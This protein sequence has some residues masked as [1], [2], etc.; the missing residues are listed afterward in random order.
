QAPGT[1]EA[2]WRSLEKVSREAQA[3]DTFV[4]LPGSYPGIL[5]PLHSGTPEAPITFRAEERRTA[6]LVGTD[7]GYHAVRL[8][9]VSHIRLEGLH[10]RP[11][12]AEGRWFYALR[13]SHITVE[14][15][16]MDDASGG[17]PFHIE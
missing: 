2:P 14:D 13:S 16:L 12:S 7:S 4:F 9:D 3:G 5:Q 15:V 17:M 6:R 8:E 1:R 10:I 11:A